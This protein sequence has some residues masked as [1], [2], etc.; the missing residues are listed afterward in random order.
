ML[1]NRSGIC[2]FETC[3][4]CDTVRYTDRSGLTRTLGEA[5]TDTLMRFHWQILFALILLARPVFAQSSPTLTLSNQTGI[6]NLTYSSSGGAV[7]NPNLY[8]YLNQ[9]GGTFGGA[10]DCLVVVAHANGTLF[11]FGT[12]SDN[13]GGDTY[14]V[15]TNATGTQNSVLLKTWVVFGVPA[16]VIKVTIPLIGNTSSSIM[17]YGGAWVEE[18][19]NGCTGVGGSGFLAF[20]AN[21]SANDL[22][23]SAA[24]TSGDTVAAFALD[25]E[26]GGTS[27]SCTGNTIAFSAGWTPI[28]DSPC[29]GKAAELNSST[30]STSVPITFGGSHKIA[31]VALVINQ[32]SAGTTPSGMYIDHEQA[33]QASSASATFTSEFPSSGNLFVPLFNAA[34]NH[35]VTSFSLSNAGS[36]TTSL[37]CGPIYNTNNN[38]ELV[39]IPYAY[40]AALSPTTSVSLTLSAASRGINPEYLSFTGAASSPFVQCSPSHTSTYCPGGMCQSGNAGFQNTA[41]NT[42]TDTITPINVGD[43][44]VNNMAVDYHTQMGLATDG[45]GH[46]PSLLSA[47]DSAADNVGPLCSFGTPASTLAGDNGY[48]ILRAA[49]NLLTTFIYTGTQTSGRCTNAPAGVQEWTSISIEFQP[50]GS[51][52]VQ[53]PTGLTA[54][55]Q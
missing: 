14:T 21:G 4:F 3:I 8:V 25:T 34:S 9:P 54:I 26:F 29:Y 44:I 50:A 38:A 43:F 53:P 16:G 49:D 51:Q 36:P 22:T 45:N 19:R 52:T 15:V 11:S 46:T 2:P 13:V 27:S 40:G 28:S 10:N 1:S 5:A 39:Q 41:A 20:T 33:D 30:T 55:V 42:S 47:V 37:G 23:L 24:P 7:S 35:G 18:F 48:S 31:M 12:P 6:D 17:A 32:G